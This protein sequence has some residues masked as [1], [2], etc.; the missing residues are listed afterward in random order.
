[1]DCLDCDRKQE[2][3]NGLC[4]HVSVEDGLLLRCVGDWSKEKHFYLEKYIDI[5]TA[6]MRKKWF[7]VYIDL[8]CG[9]GKCMVRESRVEIDGSPLIAVKSKYS[10]HKYYFVDLNLSAIDSLQK[11]C[12]NSLENDKI[13]FVNNDCNKAI[14]T[15]A[16]DIKSNMLSLAFIDPTGL[17]AKYDLLKELAGKRTDLIINFPLGMAIKRNMKQSFGIEES[18]MDEFV[19]DKGWK[20]C[21]NENEFVKYYEN[22]I[23]ELGYTY[24]EPGRMI[25]NNKNV[26]MYYLLFA[27]KSKRAAEFWNKIHRIEYGGQRTLF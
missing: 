4:K 15:I 6:S 23:R 1:M 17:N 19:G 27:T 8:F 5:F 26:P 24:I 10:F 18:A 3:E 7:L 9:P 12:K 11:R 16:R 22:R 14:E 20:N 13:I 25:R 2:S 21:S